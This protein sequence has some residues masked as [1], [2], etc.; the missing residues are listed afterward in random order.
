MSDNK[1]IFQ[2]ITISAVIFIFLLLVAMILNLVQIS[3]L[4]SQKRELEAVLAAGQLQKIR[5]EEQIELW[6][7]DEWID[8][9]AREYLDMVGD[10]EEVFVAK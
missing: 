5:N 7:S 8:A 2:I 9:Y 3:K 6:S 4:K 1:K 10:G